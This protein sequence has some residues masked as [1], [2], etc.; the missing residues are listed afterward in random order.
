[1][2]FEQHFRTASFTDRIP[3]PIKRYD[4]FKDSSTDDDD[5]DDDSEAYW[6]SSH[7]AYSSTV[8]CFALIIYVWVQLQ[9][10]VLNRE[11]KSFSAV[12]WLAHF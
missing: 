11:C 9:Y 10:Y 12:S 7:S 3:L 5:D 1:M 6:H 2:S 8:S 4:N